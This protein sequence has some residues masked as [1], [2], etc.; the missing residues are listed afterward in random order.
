M[1]LILC[2]THMPRGMFPHVH[3]NK[4]IIWIYTVYVYIP[5]YVYIY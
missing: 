1:D 2:Y 3:I 5:G 4:K